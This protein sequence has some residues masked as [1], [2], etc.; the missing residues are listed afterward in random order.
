MSQSPSRQPHGHSLPRP[1]SFLSLSCHWCHDAQA[2]FVGPQGCP[3]S[4]PQPQ[5]PP[6]FPSLSGHKRRNPIFGFTDWVLPYWPLGTD[7]GQSQEMHGATHPEPQAGCTLD[8]PPLILD[9]ERTY[10]S[11]F[12]PHLLGPLALMAGSTSSS[13]ADTSRVVGLSPLRLCPIT[14]L[15]FSCNVGVPGCP[16][17]SIYKYIYV[18]FITFKHIDNNT[19]E[20]LRSP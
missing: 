7:P 17:L 19:T 11:W 13:K 8:S 18:F 9:T 14:Q 2:A 10:S 15:S 6:C 16:L 20:K 4:H 3:P 5:S 1:V 12:G